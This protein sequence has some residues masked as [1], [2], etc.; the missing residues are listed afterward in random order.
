MIII[1]YTLLSVFRFI[2]AVSS[3]VANKG[4]KM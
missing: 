1:A 2:L 4:Y 3:L